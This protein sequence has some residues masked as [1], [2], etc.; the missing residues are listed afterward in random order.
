MHSILTGLFWFMILIIILCIVA[1]Y[2]V[3]YGNRQ[4]KRELEYEEFYKKIAC[5][6]ETW[7]VGSIYY[8][9]IIRQLEKLGQMK[10]KNKEK[11]IVLTNRF[12]EKFAVERMKRIIDN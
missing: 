1:Y 11:T 7:P 2:I 9:L 12:W 4:L 10:F 6:I 8:N 3:Y 5:N